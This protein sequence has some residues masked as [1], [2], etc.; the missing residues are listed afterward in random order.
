MLRARAE[1]TTLVVGDGTTV[2]VDS[3]TYTSISQQVTAIQ[4]ASGYGNLNFTVS[5]N[6]SNNGFKYTYKTTGAVS[7]APTFTGTG[8]SHSVSNTT[9]SELLRSM[10]QPPPLSPCHR[11]LHPAL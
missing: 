3:A 5:A 2:S 6:D 10:H 9:R 8:S 7:T 4:G 11:I 1:T